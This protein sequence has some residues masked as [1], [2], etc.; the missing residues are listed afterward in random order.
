MRLLL[1]THI[2]LWFATE[3]ERLSPGELGVILDPDNEI[4]VSAV[5]IWELRIKWSRRY[6]SG[7]R[8]GPTNPIGLLTA[9]R[10]FGLTLIPLTAEQGA[11]TLAI[12]LGHN[13]PF[14]ELLLTV[15]QETGQKLLTRDGKLADHPLAFF[16]R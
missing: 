15:A 7:Q 16:A 4:T 13:D 8:K 12:P 14:D 3:R 11:S 2:V 10:E 5:S 9:L 6:R 1:D